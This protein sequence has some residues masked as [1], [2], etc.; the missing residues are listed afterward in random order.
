M[1]ENIQSVKLIDGFIDNIWLEKGLSKNT[2]SAYRQDLINFSNWLKK[3]N[4]IE[5]KK[6]E[7]LDYLSYRLKQGYSSRSTARSLSSLRAFYSYL[8]KNSYINDDPTA[9]IDSPKLGHSLP[10]VI[11]EID[12]EKLL[13]SP[14][15]KEPLG[16][17]DRSM[18]E[19]LYA[20]GLRIS[21][22]ITLDLLNVNLRQGVIKVIGKGS[23]ERLI[24][25][26][27]EAMNWVEKYISYGR[28]ELENESFNTSILFLNRRG[29]PMSRQAF[30]YR[31]KHYAFESG[32]KASLSPHTIRHAF[33]THLINHGADLRTVQLLLGHT[34]L[35][36]TQIYTEV[37]RQ[38][39][40]E[41]HSEH[42]PRG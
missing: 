35:S 41:L 2:L 28:P 33:A 22:L 29:K 31:I 25:M 16:L 7:L 3:K 1:T 37:A 20:C 30:W 12:V 24:P 38:R 42:H 5:V 10:K 23:K 17:R 40:K 21:E 4:L 13:N 34:S 36:T 27:E 11:S 14:K 8:L 18:L 26:G 19:L 9:K 39:M 32:I 6:T 15:V